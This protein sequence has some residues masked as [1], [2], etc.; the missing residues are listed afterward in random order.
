MIKLLAM[1]I[2]EVTGNIPIEVI[3]LLAKELR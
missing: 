2:E 1:G 3:T